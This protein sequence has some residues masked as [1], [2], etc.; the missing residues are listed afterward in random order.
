MRKL[1]TVFGG[2]H[3]FHIRTGDLNPHATRADG[4]VLTVRGS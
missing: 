1:F 3:I 2:Q 4:E